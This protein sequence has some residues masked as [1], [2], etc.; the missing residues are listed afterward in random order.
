LWGSRFD[1]DRA[2]DQLGQEERVP[3]APGVQ[4]AAGDAEA[5]RGLDDREPLEGNDAPG[6]VGMDPMPA[7]EQCPD[8]RLGQ[9]GVSGQAPRLDRGA[10]SEQTEERQLQ[11][12]SPRVEVLRAT[13][14][15]IREL[16][17]VDRL[18]HLRP[19]AGIVRG[20]ILD[21]TNM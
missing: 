6:L 5:V 1:L 4:L 9:P 17:G 18:G 2:S 21:S 14:D 13:A 3:G 11:T 15:L 8:L 12:L 19:G 10:F 7:A 20:I 16:R